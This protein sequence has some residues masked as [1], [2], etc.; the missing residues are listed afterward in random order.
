MQSVRIDARCSVCIRGV[1]ERVEGGM[2]CPSGTQQRSKVHR[3]RRWY[4]GAASCCCRGVDQYLLHRSLFLAPDAD[5]AGN[6]SRT[7]V[8]TAACGASWPVPAVIRL[9][10]VR[11]FHDSPVVPGICGDLS[12]AFWS[13]T[14]ASFGA[15]EMRLLRVQLQ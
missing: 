7:W 5:N 3:E 1:S 11:R 8:I 14:A 13:V 15:S 6:C 12:T 4:M 10:G 9:L 2:A